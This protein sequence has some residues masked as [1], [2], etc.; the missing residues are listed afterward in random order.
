V[1]I[2]G[3]QLQALKRCNARERMHQQLY[4]RICTLPVVQL[5]FK[6]QTRQVVQVLHCRKQPVTD[7]LDWRP[8]DD[9]TERLQS[10][11]LPDCSCDHRCR[12]FVFSERDNVLK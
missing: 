8:S 10:M 1:R 3:A 12:I 7:G 9:D 6:P 4:L 5:H 2:H 11:Q